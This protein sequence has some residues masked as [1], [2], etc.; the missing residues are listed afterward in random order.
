MF[1]IQNPKSQCAIDHNVMIRFPQQDPLSF[2]RDRKICGHSGSRSVIVNWRPGGH[3]QPAKA[4][5][6][7]RRIIM[8]SE[9]AEK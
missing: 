3:I 4:F 8:N 6:P 1:Q 9:N 7:T 2:Q 5:S